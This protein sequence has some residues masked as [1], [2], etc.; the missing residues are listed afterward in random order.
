MLL[1]QH[2]LGVCSMDA[3]CS[4]LRT[5][6]H[7]ICMYMSTHYHPHKQFILSSTQ[8]EGNSK[9]GTSYG[10]WK[11]G[12]CVRS[13]IPCTNCAT[14]L[15]L[16]L[17]WWCPCS[18]TDLS[19]EVLFPLQVTGSLTQVHWLNTIYSILLHGN[20]RSCQLGEICIWLLSRSA[21]PKDFH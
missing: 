21:V 2:C 9:P 13:Y 5:S 19:G 20:L 17:V 15:G 4:S 18:V 1:H 14:T 10:T 12:V 11:C 7:V 8:S 3:S 6:H 16:W